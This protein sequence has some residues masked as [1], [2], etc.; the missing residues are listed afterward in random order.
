MVT[1]LEL[2][3]SI[4][5]DKKL[6]KETEDEA[7]AICVA[8][9]KGLYIALGG[10]KGIPLPDKYDSVVADTEIVF[11]YK[12][13]LN[14]LKDRYTKEEYKSKASSFLVKTLEKRNIH[15]EFRVKET[16]FI[17]TSIAEL[18]V[19]LLEIDYQHEISSA[20]L[21]LVYD[22]VLNLLE[23]IDIGR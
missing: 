6:Y 15:N 7:L 22:T 9:K 8:V 11:T 19:D 16:P 2:R 4:S 14:Y 12:L 5:N 3:D 23:N 10:K 17:N 1:K 20:V 18:A 21:N 13:K